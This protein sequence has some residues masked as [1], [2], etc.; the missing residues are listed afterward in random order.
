VLTLIFLVDGIQ[1]ETPEDTL[2]QW[3]FLDA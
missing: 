2:S 3:R 1:E